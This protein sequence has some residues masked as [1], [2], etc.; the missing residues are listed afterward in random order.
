MILKLLNEFDEVGG[1][2]SYFYMMQFRK[3]GEQIEVAIVRP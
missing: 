2:Y 3:E 1:L